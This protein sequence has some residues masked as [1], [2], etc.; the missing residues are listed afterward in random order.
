MLF[1]VSYVETNLSYLNGV[2]SHFIQK[3]VTLNRYYKATLFPAEFIPIHDHSQNAIDTK[4]KNVFKDIKGLEP[5]DKK[6]L[7]RLYVN[8]QRIQKLCE[9]KTIPKIELSCLPTE[10]QKSLKELGEYLY[11][12]GLKNKAI[13]KLANGGNDQGIDSLLSHSQRFREVNGDVC[14]FCGI[15]D[16]EEQLADTD[17][18]KQW[19]PAY[20]HFLPKDKY[21]L[22]AVNFKNLFPV[23][24]QCNSKAKGAIDPCYCKANSQRKV[25]FY[26]FNNNLNGELFFSY[27]TN[28]TAILSNEFWQVELGDD[29]DENQL[30]WDRVFDI[31][32]RVKD[33]LNRKY[34]KWLKSILAGNDLTIDELKAHLI[35]AAIE[36][37]E[38][39]RNIRDGYHKA[40]TFGSLAT[41]SHDL[42]EAIVSALSNEVIP[43][44]K[45]EALIALNELGFD[46]G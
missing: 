23:C 45:D 30:T 35:A 9:K 6:K 28:E 17:D 15:N 11:S 21:P 26:P 40:L 46:F 10:L 13:R 18:T 43:S 4:F 25:S 20:D 7:L 22:A 5:S 19:R 27:A 3:S 33:R 37:M 8:H 41:M 2:L 1:P 39:K 38:E 24:Y 16:Y 42:L 36:N 29:K 12:S 14:C 32:N 34:K 44:S 31:T